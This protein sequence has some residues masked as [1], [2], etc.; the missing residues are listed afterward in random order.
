MIECPIKIGTL[1]HHADVFKAPEQ[2]CG[3]GIVIKIINENYVV[4]HWAEYDCFDYVD[5]ANLEV[6]DESGR[7]S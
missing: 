4:V 3:L 6:I 1:V 2:N 5:I 7:F